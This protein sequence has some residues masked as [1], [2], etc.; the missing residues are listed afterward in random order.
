MMPDF[1]ETEYFNEIL[2]NNQPMAATTI[3]LDARVEFPANKVWQSDKGGSDYVSLKCKTLTGTSPNGKDPVV[4]ANVG[5][6]EQSI[7]AAYRKGDPVQ[8]A[9]DGKKYSIVGSASTLTTANNTTPPPAQEPPKT[10]ETS[11]EK[12]EKW[13]DIYAHI[14]NHLSSKMPVTTPAEVVGSAASTVFIALTRN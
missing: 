9:Y 3:V 10:K 8:L 12:A 14:F 2:E 11:L 1:N 5:S 6:P 4:Y 7:L 13:A